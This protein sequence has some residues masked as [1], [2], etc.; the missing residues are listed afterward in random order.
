MAGFNGEQGGNR[1]FSL[2]RCI[3][4]I[5]VVWWFDVAMLQYYIVFVGSIKIMSKMVVLVTK[6]LEKHGG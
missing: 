3:E 4:V 5:T 1:V 6:R 2:G